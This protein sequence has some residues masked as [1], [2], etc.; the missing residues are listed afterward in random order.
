[1]LPTGDWYGLGLGVFQPDSVG[2]FGSD[3]GGASL[4]G[5]VPESGVVFALLINRGGDLVSNEAA[6]PLVRAMEKP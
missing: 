6:I 3:P 2:H 5:C 1:M 4:A